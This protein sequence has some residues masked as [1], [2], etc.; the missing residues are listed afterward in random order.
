MNGLSV[1]CSNRP[2]PRIRQGL[3]SL[4]QEPSRSNCRDGFLYRPDRDLPG[5]I[6]LLRDQ[7]RSARIL[8]FNATEHST[9]QWIVQQ[10][11]E[12]FPEDSAP[13][14]LILDRGAK[15]N[16]DVARMLEC[17]DSKLIRTAHHSP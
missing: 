15:F 16:G 5:T 13:K 9:S 6:M 11:R 4:S 8:H 12:V 17:L 2:S 3:V 10:L 1:S 7:P 14:Y